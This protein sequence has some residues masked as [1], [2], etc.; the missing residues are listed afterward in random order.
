MHKIIQVALWLAVIIFAGCK[1]APIL[2]DGGCN[3]FVGLAD[4]SKF[5]HL[6]NESGK[7]I[8]ISPT[9]TSRRPWNELVV[10]WNA[11]APAGTFLKIEAAAV[12]ADHETKFFTLGNWSPDNKIFPRTSVGGQNDAD[13]K[14]ATDTLILKQ[15][16]SAAR[17]RVTLGGTNGL[18]PT[19]KFI[20]IS[21]SNTRIAPATR[22][23]NHAAWGRI[24]PTPERLQHGYPGEKGWCSP[25]SLS[26]ALA[27][28][29]EQ[30]A[31]GQP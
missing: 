1:T 17:I 20:G 26:M 25:T 19:L 30:M 6:Q 28:W 21:F 10:S 24:I 27:R 29:A 16:A 5:T 23:P 31:R 9:I 15:T 7:T 3:Q 18:L 8:L 13:G 22:A 12:L 4:F 11:D 2:P 14:V